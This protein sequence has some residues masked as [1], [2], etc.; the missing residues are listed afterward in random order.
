MPYLSIPIPSLT[1][2]VFPPALRFPPCPVIR[3]KRVVYFLFNDITHSL[4][5]RYVV[6]YILA[7]NYEDVIPVQFLQRIL[8]QN[9]NNVYN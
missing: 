4:V 2:S 8:V 6:R 5:V 3:I 7:E 9:C 1:A